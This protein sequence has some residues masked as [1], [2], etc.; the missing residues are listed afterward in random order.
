MRKKT[1]LLFNLQT[2]T[3][4]F[5]L[6]K[7]EETLNFSKQIKQVFYLF[8]ECMLPQ[9]KRNNHINYLPRCTYHLLYKKEIDFKTELFVLSKYRQ[10]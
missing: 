10:K 3:I 7:M 2:F 1:H 8:L 5:N 4:L 6:F 9:R